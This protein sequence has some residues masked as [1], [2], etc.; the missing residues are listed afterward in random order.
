MSKENSNRVK[1]V[2]KNKEYKTFDKCTL[3]KLEA[4]IR[5]PYLNESIDNWYQRHPIIDANEVYDFNGSRILEISAVGKAIQSSDDAYDE[6]IGKRLAESRAKKAIYKF[7]ETLFRMLR[8]EANVKMAKYENTMR[9][10]YK[11]GEKEIE[12]QHDIVHGE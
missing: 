4:Y 1:C 6:K 10:F 2:F 7:C 11:F 3:C 12:H 9:S 5:I 8:D